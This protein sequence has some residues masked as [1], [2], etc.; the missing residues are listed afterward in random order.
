M[1][2]DPTREERLARKRAATRR[3][4]QRRKD[5]RDRWL[6]SPEGIEDARKAAELLEGLLQVE[7]ASSGA[8]RVSEVPGCR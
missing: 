1:T 7:S 6:R 2:E 8:V 5:E 4:T 3:A